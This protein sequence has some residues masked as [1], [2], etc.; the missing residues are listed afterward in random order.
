M[1]ING[2]K[3]S[4]DTFEVLTAG[5]VEQ[6]QGGIEQALEKTGVAFNDQ[7]ALKLLAEG[8]CDVDFVTERVRFPTNLVRDYMAKCPSQFPVKAREAENDWDLG[9]PQTTYFI[10]S[11]ASNTIDLDTFKPRQPTR[12]E[13][14]DFMK[15]LD[16]LPNVHGLPSFPWFG[17]ARV[18]QAMCLV[19]SC[20][21]K[22]RLSSKVQM[23]GS[24]HDNEI[25]NI[26]MGQATGQDILQ[27]LNP[28]APLTYAEDVVTK[29]MRYTEEDMPFHIASGPVPGATGPATV[30]G[31]V[32]SCSV[33][34]ISAMVFAQMLKP[35]ARVWSG[36]M[37]LGQ[38]M[39]TGSPMFGQVAN[40]LL[41][42]AF[43]QVW[44][45]YQ[46]PSWSIIPAWTDSKQIDYQAA[47]ETSMPA[48]LA[49]LCG[50]STVWFQGGISQ[51]LSLHPV[52]AVID[53]DVAGMIGRMLEGVTV[54]DETMA[55][56]LIDE[57][58]PI[59]GNFLITAHTRKWWKKEQYL[60]QVADHGSYADFFK[61]GSK[62]II[63]R[64]QEK[65]DDMLAT[66]KPSPLP[67]LQEQAVEE[68]LT[69]A[70][71]HYRESGLISDD[72]WELYQEDLNSPDYPFA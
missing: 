36:N 54:D 3:R 58:G 8:G 7:R 71:Q 19:E 40:F 27:L 4:F 48:L 64:A 67:A 30:A 62:T 25:W 41:D 49:A 63:Q 70:R 32:I 22:V 60:A 72:E 20:A 55:L 43:Q 68:I 31:S 50:A 66:H 23:E 35:G 26:K 57:V 45:E 34:H 1:A 17:F 38:N 12:K 51:Q 69:E 65:M 10:A 6:I 56:D 13:F 28:A 29:I 15:L 33:E 9:D 39:R 24:V 46:I 11:C 42:A 2:F 53:D 61:E 5:Q 14:Y 44:R 47:Y 21:A 16:A 18:P 52:K 37:V 59:P